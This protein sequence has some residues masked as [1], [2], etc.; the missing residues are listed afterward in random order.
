MMKFRCAA[1]ILALL[2]LFP[3][4]P[5]S[6]ADD[7]GSGRHTVIAELSADGD[8]ARESFLRA[9]RRLD[10]ALTVLYAYDELLSGFALE[11]SL[12]PALLEAI[13][14]AAAVTLSG[15]R[16]AETVILASGSAAPAA[17]TAAGGSL[18]AVWDGFTERGEGM[19]AA[20]I[21]ACFDVGHPLLT[22][23]DETSARI[24]EEDVK[25][26]MKNGL[27]AAL[28]SGGPSASS[29]TA[30]TGSLYV[31]AKIPFAYDY[32]GSD[33][34]VGG[35]LDH[36]TGVASLIGGNIAGDPAGFDGCAPECQ[37]LL[38]KV[39]DDRGQIRDEAVI[40]ALE[41]AIALGADV[42]NLSIGSDCGSDGCL[43]DASYQRLISRAAA[44]GVEIFCAAGN[45]GRV[46]DGYE[47]ALGV[48]DPLPDNPDTGTVA[49][50]AVLP[51]TVSVASCEFDT[52]TQT[53]YLTVG[54]KIVPYA[55]G[56]YSDL[57]GDLG[58]GSYSYAIVPGVGRPDDYN[59]L[60]VRG[61]I[62]VTERGTI[63]FINKIKAAKDAG[64]S[65]LIVTGNTDDD[66]LI[67][68]A[69]EEDSI[70][71]VY[72]TKASGDL[73]RKT[74]S[75]PYGKV[76][77]KAGA[78]SV[79]NPD[80]GTM[81]SFSSWGPS[82]TLKLKP[83][84]TA[85]GGTL[86]TAANGGGYTLVRGTSFSSPLAA[87]WTLLLR[88]RRGD[89]TQYGAPY[90]R[91]LLAETAVPL[92][93]EDGVEVSPRRQGAGVIDLS[94]AA[95]ASAAVYGEDGQTAL[96]LGDGLGSSFTIPFSVRGY[97]GKQS[98]RVSVSLLTEAVEK[99]GDSGATVIAAYDAA[100][101]EAVVT[102]GGSSV[103]VNRNADGFRAS[104]C[105]TVTVTDNQP[106]SC[107][108]S[109]KLSAKETAALKKSFPNGGY[110]EGYVYL[111]P[112]G[113]SG[114]VMSVP[115]L[116]F[117]GGWGALPVFDE[118][119]GDASLIT[120]VPL[121]RT[122]LTFTLGDNSFADDPMPMPVAFSPD[123]DGIGDTLGV[124]FPARRG[125]AV[126]RAE[127]VSD[128][129]GTENSWD[130]TPF[131]RTLPDST[132]VVD[133]L[134]EAAMWDGT[135]PDNPACYLPD[136]RYELRIWAAAD[137]PDAK[138]QCLSLPF[139]ID[140]VDPKIADL[141]RTASRLE[142]TASD[143]VGLQ[144][145]RIYE[146]GAS[147]FGAEEAAEEGVFAE[148][149]LFSGEK[150]A[151]RT[152]DLDGRVPEDTVLYMEVLDSAYNLTVLRIEP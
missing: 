95:A 130:L 84:L 17:S 123:G 40:A 4:L 26:A 126:A 88:Q 87:G 25:T 91:R 3:A 139:V 146:A 131:L 127:I 101:T 89:T 104:A 118:N 116:G 136:G 66:E 5:L 67:T 115:F 120:S 77:L 31:S 9:A 61:K 143:N 92:T 132:S 102:V 45:A 68:L 147:P 50:P 7:A 117:S 10:P 6:A 56:Q 33:A 41:D 76:S 2:L 148:E 30:L 97:A 22:M 122:V 20:V 47:E 75:G 14:G 110:L 32:C 93:D 150:S 46:G 121:G 80:A 73:L 28:R 134:T 140:T 98:W 108:I 35:K 83:D 79:A 60:D 82:P 135:D 100:L 58:A 49:S 145:I 8:G 43:A 86:R 44:R 133:R 54:G 129:N 12:D 63:T 52:L 114:P 24:S 106:V 64:A 124:S 151:R 13:P 34:D 109:V 19:V 90:I 37:L 53:A 23:T 69:M 55:D 149:L 112:A 29:K 48:T 59:G 51:A 138:E 94:A 15:A 99:D 42:I 21:D 125:A 128:D 96:S 74:A 16:T 85:P 111:T 1:L 113:F 72:V 39:A 105:P 81:S 152:V 119:Y 18:N 141:R 36:G 144:Y 57:L 70:P 137:W 38:M 78:V 11:T 27:H 62:A 103:N 71:A 65:A 107:E 142:F